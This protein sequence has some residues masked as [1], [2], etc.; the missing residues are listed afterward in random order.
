MKY[1]S[2]PT[3]STGASRKFID[4]YKALMDDINAG[5]RAKADAAMAKLEIGN[6]FEDAYFGV[7]TYSY[8]SKW[9]SES[10]QLAALQRAIANEEQP[11]YLPPDMFKATLL[12]RM[13][14]E[15]KT[16]QYAEAL[17]TAKSLKK[18]GVDQKTD[19]TLDSVIGQLEKVRSGDSE[20]QVAGVLSEG[21]WYL[22]LFKRHFRFVVDQGHISGIRIWCD[23]EYLHFDFDPAQQH[24]VPDT[25]GDCRI[26]VEGAAGTQF[27]LVQF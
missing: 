27:K 2:D 13:K 5:D 26:G 23:K 20:Y 17:A 11:Y 12:A 24:Y 18:V 9:G 8:A 16:N 14:L 19:A 15:L 1:R 10:E 6:L 4:S 25:A 21:P 22:H 7:A 3:P